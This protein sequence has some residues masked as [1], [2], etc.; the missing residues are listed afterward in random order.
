[1]KA[2]VRPPSLPPFIF[3]F[4]SAHA[5]VDQVVFFFFFFFLLSLKK[6]KR[7]VHRAEPRVKRGVTNGHTTHKEAKKKKE[8]DGYCITVRRNYCRLLFSYFLAE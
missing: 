4:Y 8:T 1:M 5:N 6:K 3:P 2:S 7:L